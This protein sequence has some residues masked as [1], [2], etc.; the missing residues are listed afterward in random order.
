M[1]LAGTYPTRF[2]ERRTAKFGYSI[3]CD[4]D[5]RGSVNDSVRGLGMRAGIV[6]PRRRI[7]QR[8]IDLLRSIG[9]EL[10]H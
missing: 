4:G 7:N 5:R 3:L 10:S 2:G 8:W 9:N 6:A 1:A